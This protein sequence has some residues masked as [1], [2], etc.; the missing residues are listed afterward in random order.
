MVSKGDAV[1][2]YSSGLAGIIAASAGNDPYRPIQAMVIAA[3]DRMAMRGYA[4]FFGVVIAGLVLWIAW[5][6]TGTKRG[7]RAHEEVV[8]KYGDTESSR[9]VVG[10]ED[11]GNP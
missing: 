5:R 2:T 10:E 1:W 11:P 7:N 8:G 6:V 3:L 4:G 9:G